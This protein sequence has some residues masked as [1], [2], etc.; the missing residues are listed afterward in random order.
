M[1]DDNAKK[2]DSNQQVNA[3][4]AELSRSE[5]ESLVG[6]RENKTKTP[7]PKPAVNFDVPPRRQHVLGG[8][9]TGIAHRPKSISNKLLDVSVVNWFVG[10]LVLAILG[11][12]FW[13]QGERS[14]S[15]VPNQISTQIEGD[16]DT[17][18]ITSTKTED[19]NEGFSRDNDL[20]RAN[21]YREQEEHDAQITRLTNKALAFVKLRQFTLPRQDNAVL[22][23]R[24]ILAIDPRNVTARQGLD[25]IKTHFEIKAY[26]ALE[27]NN[28]D[29]A[30]EALGK[31]QYVEADSEQV[32]SVTQAIEQFRLRQQRDEFLA[33]AKKAFKARRLTLPAKNNSLYFFQQAL[34]IDPENEEA[35]AGVK[36][37]ADE[38]IEKA[39]D[40]V[41]KGEFSRAAAHL[42]TVSII[43][44]QHNSIPLIE[45]MIE[46]AKPIAEAAKQNQQVA[47]AA[48]QQGAGAQAEPPTEAPANEQVSDAEPEPTEIEQTAQTNTR[49]P[50]NQALE[51]AQFD[52]QYLLRGLSSY[53]KGDYQQAAALLQPLADK[54]IAR[55]QFRLG[56]MHYLGRGFRRD[57]EQADQI[58]RSALPAIQRFAEEGR[59]WAQSD[60]GSL[61]ED[62]L[63][64]RRDFGEA[65]YWYRSAAEQGYP[66]AQTNL[67]IMY[68]RGRG[69]SLSR[70][71]A[72]EWF[73]RA[74]KQ[75][76]VVAQRN[77]EAMGVN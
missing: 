46:R 66:G 5:I 67:G 72:I 11:A 77:L 23:Y 61:Y 22:R 34:L 2:T 54:G 45:A 31:L 33:D 30:E 60:L 10:I 16:T 21:N 29:G 3:K 38:F 8:D 28:E 76:D 44:P 43:D 15:E 20:D 12:F 59:A 69:V 64:L 26:N 40:A 36:S 49:T 35:L 75:G 14:V 32:A 47:A 55:A 24:E 39:N 68:A 71:T 18:E 65:V 48:Q 57:R 52:Q 73:Q 17:S 74:A 50:S 9:L 41:L 1:Q 25:D 56:Y 4:P 42:A 53:Y 62:G 51:Q 13:P 27:A 63:V 37:I 7:P 6:L 19:E 58:I 70:R